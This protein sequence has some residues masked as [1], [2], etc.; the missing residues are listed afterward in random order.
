VTFQHSQSQV[1]AAE[2]AEFLELKKNPKIFLVVGECGDGKST[3]INALRDPL[4]S[5]EPKAGL[6]SRGVTKNIEAFVA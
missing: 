5:G 1:G 3:L 4:R 6:C 2:S